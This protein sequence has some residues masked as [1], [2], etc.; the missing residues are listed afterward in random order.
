MKVVDA[1]NLAKEI[2]SGTS[3][4]LLTP[5]GTITAVYG[6]PK[7]T[8]DLVV[9]GHFDVAKKWSPKSY[10]AV[11]NSSNWQVYKNGD[12]VVEAEVIE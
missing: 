9:N 10:N 4:E 6:W 7:G 5:R 2:G 11:K 12:L 1:L 3:V 8:I